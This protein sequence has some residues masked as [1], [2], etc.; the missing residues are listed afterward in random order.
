MDSQKPAVDS[1]AAYIASAPKNTRDLLQAMRKT[2]REAAPKATEKI[3]YRMPTFWLNGNLVHFA[4]FANH[5]G[6]YPDPSGISKFAKQLAAY[7]GA[8]GSVQFPLD[9]PLPL[10]LIARIVRFRVK[11]NEA[12]EK[13]PPKESA[14][15]SVGKSAKHPARQSIKKD[16]KG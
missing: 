9:Q 6:F 2:I 11:E 3:S 14:K 1:I 4:V 7:K 16:R 13:S 8:K 5:I 12:K 10:D 15:K